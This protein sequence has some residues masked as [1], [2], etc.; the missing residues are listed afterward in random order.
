MIQHA[1]AGAHRGTSVTGSVAQLDLKST[2]PRPEFRQHALNVEGE[3]SRNSVSAQANQN[4]WGLVSGRDTPDMKNG[5]SRF[6]EW[7][8]SRKS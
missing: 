3:L 4:R 8:D 1:L 5:H 7:P 6:R 2:Q